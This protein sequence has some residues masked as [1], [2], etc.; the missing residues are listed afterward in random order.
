M[1]DKF[2]S[3]VTVLPIT[4][5]VV[6]QSCG[7]TPQKQL[8][9]DC[10]SPERERKILFCHLLH[11]LPGRSLG[12]GFLITNFYEF[13]VSYILASILN[14]SL[15]KVSSLLTYY[16]VLFGKIIPDIKV[17]YCLSPLGSSKQHI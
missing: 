1:V 14:P 10:V 5:H 8:S 12:R 13:L 17:S 9:Q 6:A 11:V 4:N 2:K 3:N 16:A 15:N 7:S